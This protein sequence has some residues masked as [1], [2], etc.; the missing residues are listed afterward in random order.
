MK[1]YLLKGFEA[2]KIKTDLNGQS[3]E[4]VVSIEYFYED[5][6]PRAGQDFDFGDPID[7]DNYEARFTNGGDLSNIGVSVI[8]RSEGLEAM[9]HL[10]QVHA[11]AK[12]FTQD[13]VDVVRDHTM[14][15][16]AVTELKTNIIEASKSLA[17]FVPDGKSTMYYVKPESESK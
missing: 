2:K 3:I 5:N 14:I 1:T 11:S 9:D 10:G 15:E 6:A 8:A 12:S 4:V 16:N 13:V 7:N 17:R